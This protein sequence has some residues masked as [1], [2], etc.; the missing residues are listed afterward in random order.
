MTAE[1]PL[2][3]PRK[4][5]NLCAPA[6]LPA[7]R[8]H[9]RCDG[10]NE[11]THRCALEFDY[12]KDTDH[13]NHGVCINTSLSH[14]LLQGRIQT[15]PPPDTVLC[16]RDFFL[17]NQGGGCLARRVCPGAR[18]SMPG[19]GRQGA[20]GRKGSM[21]H[22][23]NLLWGERAGPSVPRTHSRFFAHRSMAQAHGRRARGS[24]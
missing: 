13:P 7:W 18:V 10:E 17:R 15:P 23:R 2:A 9:G 5:L 12:P 8:R 3:C 24:R 11:D 21:R 4:N 16:R 20:V 1:N 6:P 14:A 19:Q 22:W